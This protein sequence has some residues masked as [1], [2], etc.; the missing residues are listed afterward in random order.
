ME[1][2][3]SAHS[4]AHIEGCLKLCKSDMRSLAEQEDVLGEWYLDDDGERLTDADLLNAS[5]WSFR[6]DGIE[7]KLIRRFIDYGSGQCWFSLGAPV[8]LGDYLR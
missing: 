7:H 3:L 4:S 2:E 5:P 1:F 8:Q 6:Q